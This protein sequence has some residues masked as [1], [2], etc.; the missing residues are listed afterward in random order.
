MPITT[1]PATLDGTAVVSAHVLGINTTRLAVLGWFT[2]HPH[3][4]LSQVAGDLQLSRETVRR[5]IESLTR[6]TALVEVASSSRRDKT[7][8]LRP[9]LIVSSVN[10]VLAV[11]GLPGVGKG[12]ADDHIG[13]DADPGG[14]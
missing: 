14:S 1:N 3:G 11:L 12:G 7:Y 5:H 13:T 9:D 10:G 2:D 4:T 6:E 8:R